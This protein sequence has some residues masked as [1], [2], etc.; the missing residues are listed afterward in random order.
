MQTFSEASQSKNHR[1]LIL[2][3]NL[4]KVSNYHNDNKAQLQRFLV[5]FRQ[6]LIKRITYYVLY[7]SFIT[8]MHVQRENGSVITSSTAARNVRT[9]A[10]NPGPSGSAVE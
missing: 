3:N 2:R 10:Q 4:K 6:T 9:N 5:I 7:F 8:L 1:S